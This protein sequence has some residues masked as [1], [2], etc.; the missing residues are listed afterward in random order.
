MHPELE[1]HLS[2]CRNLPSPPGVALRIIE[3]AQ[4]PD[5][6]MSTAADTIGLDPALSA[7]MLRIANSPLYAS[8]R[9]VENL[10]QALT[11]LGLNATLT[12]ALGFSLSQGTRSG[13]QPAAQERIWRRSVIAALASRLLGQYTGQRKLEELM[14]AGLLQDIG[15][16]AL[17]QLYPDDYAALTELASD[18]TSLV[19][20]ERAWLG[21]DHAAAGNWMARQWNLPVLLQEAIGESESSASTTPFNACVAVSGYVADIWLTHQPE[22]TQLAHGVAAEQAATRLGMDYADFLA[23]T[24]QMVKTLPEVCAM[25]DVPAS[26]PARIEALL[27]QARELLVVRNLREIQDAARARKDADESESRARR[28]AE[29]VRRDPLTGVYN[30]GQLE[31]VL[32]REFDTATRHGWPLS[33]AFIDLDDFKQVNDRWGHLVGDEVLRNF[34]KTLVKHV[35]GSDIVARYGGEEFLV[36]LP[37]IAEDAAAHVVRRILSEVSQ[38]AMAQV[39]G[40]PLHITFSAGLAT[41][42]AL[43]QFQDVDSLLRAADDALYGAKRDGRNR[44]AVGAISG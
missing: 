44:V 7:R 25:F 18:N 40:V 21:C 35:R 17:L 32:E 34:A 15:M 29:E 3:L 30:R 36:V 16:L 1:A 42:G 41:Q 37:G 13:Q 22:S 23:L 4:N 9:R 6:V 39:D 8:R 38:V 27:E 28:L 26:S 11:L 31:T 14:L 10:S 5:V 33:I 19:L 2:H 43:D 12:L 20:A 24:E